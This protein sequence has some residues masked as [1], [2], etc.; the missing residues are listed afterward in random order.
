MYELIILSLL[1]RHPAH[2]YLISKII[3]DIIGPYA[4]ISNGRLYPLLAKLEKAGLIMFE[5]GKEAVNP[6]EYARPLH[7]YQIT[8]AGRQRFHQLMMDITSNPGEYQK[9]F[10][11]KVAYFDLLSTAD[12]LRLIDH[13]LT[14]C[15]THILH[16]TAEAQDMITNQAE[17]KKHSSQ[18]NA[19]VEV[20][21]HLIDQWQLELAW[22][23]HLR[24]KAE[25][26]EQIDMMAV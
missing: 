26:S 22:A 21:H 16:L 15:H 5:T 12:R 20:M 18:L 3:N 4:K 9:L 25:I 6:P 19:I 13:Y 7:T 10:A 24:E 17:Y 8:E 23:K 11:Q 2:G 1:M 14:Y